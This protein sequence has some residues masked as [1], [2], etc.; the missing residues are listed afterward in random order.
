M[1]RIVVVKRNQPS[2]VVVVAVGSADGLV[3]SSCP[4]EAMLLDCPR[5]NVCGGGCGALSTFKWKIFR[6]LPL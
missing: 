2:E 4:V 6:L 3:R 1:V 5:Q